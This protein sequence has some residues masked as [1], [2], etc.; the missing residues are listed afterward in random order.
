LSYADFTVLVS[1]RPRL[2]D[3][4]ISTR[5]TSEPSER[6]TSPF[7]SITVIQLPGIRIF[8]LQLPA[9]PVLYPSRAMSPSLL[10]NPSIPELDSHTFAEIRPETHGSDGGPKHHPYL[11]GDPEERGGTS[12]YV[13]S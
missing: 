12:L 1:H 6:A 13:T 5:Q 9:W 3:I 4:R 7:W 10:A 2:P 8:T 11:A